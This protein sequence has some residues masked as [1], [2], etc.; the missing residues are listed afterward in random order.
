MVLVGCAERSRPASWG[1]YPI[2]FARALDRPAN[3]GSLS[4]LGDSDVGNGI[5]RRVADAACG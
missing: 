3:G 4:G 1:G 5:A 2:D